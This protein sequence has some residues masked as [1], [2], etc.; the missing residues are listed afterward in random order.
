M[1]YVPANRFILDFEWTVGRMVTTRVQEANGLFEFSIHEKGRKKILIQMK[2][3]V[4]GNQIFLQ[5]YFTTT[6]ICFNLIISSHLY[7]I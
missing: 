7:H 4:Q 2:E 1:H 5:Q 3:R 6:R